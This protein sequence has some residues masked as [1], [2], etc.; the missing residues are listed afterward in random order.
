LGDQF[1]ARNFIRD[2][3]TAG[4]YAKDGAFTPFVDLFKGMFHVLKKDDVY[5]RWVRAGG[6]YSHM[7]GADK[8]NLQESLEEVM[9]EPGAAS[10]VTEMMNPLH[11]IRTLQNISTLMEE[12]TRVGIFGKAL[13]SGASPIV[14]ANLSTATFGP[15]A[16]IVNAFLFIGLDLTTRDALHDRWQGRQL[17][18]R[19]G[20]LIAAGGAI[21]YLLN[22][23]AGQIA[24]A[25]VVAFTLAATADG[26]VY[27]VLGER[28]YLV[29][30]NG[31]NVVGAAVDSLVFPTIAFGEILPL[32]VLGQFAAK[33]AGGFVWSVVLNALSVRRAEA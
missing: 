9:R 32:V 2:Q 22:A 31:S 26:L 3:F 24:I 11:P 5:N 7:V 10:F 21:S 33:V 17:V 1:I 18:I 4:V 28:T 23:G 25:S 6:R 30:V 27:S 19:M 8:T 13:G 16:S 14:A 15:A 20:A 29:R 12:S